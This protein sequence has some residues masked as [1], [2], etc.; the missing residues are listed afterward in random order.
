MK[1][2]VRF[3]APIALAAALAIPVFAQGCS[4]AEELCC[5]DPTKVEIEG[6]AGAQ[7]SVA[8]GAAADLAAVAQG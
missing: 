1:K 6:Q 2:S 7:F 8:V 5:T 3:S 4:A